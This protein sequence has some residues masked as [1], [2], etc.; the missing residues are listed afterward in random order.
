VNAKGYQVDAS[1]AGLT[2]VHNGKLR[3]RCM[4]GF[5]PDGR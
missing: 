3:V 2:E 4:P 5:I 1:L